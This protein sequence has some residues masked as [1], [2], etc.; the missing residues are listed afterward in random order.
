MERDA[1]PESA[2]PV[3]SERADIPTAA[4]AFRLT[5]ADKTAIARTLA[6]FV[7]AAVERRDPAAGYDLATSRLRGGLS[8]SA[9][10]R[11]EIPV[12]PF[13]TRRSRFDDWQLNYAAGNEVSVELM[14]PARHQRELGGIT[15][16][17]VLERTRDR[18]LVDSF[19]PTATFAAAGD[20][21]LMR[22]QPDFAP[23]A[24]GV[25]SQG[26]GADVSRSG[27][28]RVSAAWLAVP[29]ALLCAAV[30]GAL[31]LLWADSRRMRT[32]R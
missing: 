18:W 1:P 3:S 23:A 27:R 7:P 17:V 12:Y 22:A 14:L 2:A 9:W 28:G 26:G 10:A 4:P 29:V 21:A 13:Q 31:A 15:F 19:T 25:A 20:T 32:A 6:V 30:L 5:R 11:G 16:T 8:R 24:R